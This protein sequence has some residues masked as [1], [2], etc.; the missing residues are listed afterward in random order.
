[1]RD[2]LREKFPRSWLFVIVLLSGGLLLSLYS[3]FEYVRLIHFPMSG[4]AICNFTETLNCE[5]AILSRYS[6]VFGISLGSFGAL[7]Y[8]LSLLFFLFFTPPEGETPDGALSG[9]FIF[10]TASLAISIALFAV[11]LLALD[12]L[13]PVCIALYLV[14]LCLW[15]TIWRMDGESRLLT[16]IKGGGSA[17]LSF[18]QYL[19]GLPRIILA[20]ESRLQDGAKVFGVLLCAMLLLCS[21]VLFKL[22]LGGIY[23]PS[24]D[25]QVLFNEWKS[26]SEEHIPFESENLYQ[27]DFRK[28]PRDAEIRIVEFFDYECPACRIF[29]FDLKDL[30]AE[31]G[32]H[33]SVEYRNYP[34]DSSCNSKL[35]TTGHQYACDAAEI[36]RCA[37]E[38]D[39]FFEA[40]EY[41]LTLEEFDSRDPQADK[42]GALRS[43]IAELE[44]DRELMIDCLSSNR[45]MIAIQRDIEIANRLNLPGTPAVWINGRRFESLR[46]L[47]DFVEHLIAQGRQ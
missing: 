42:G 18:T 47:R 2:Y 34:L 30:I 39:Q 44:L 4:D 45:Q 46:S 10:A 19:G 38:Q 40:H 43:I 5:S 15:I 11:S 28:G 27:R 3:S 17:V 16:R 21:D 14:S 36:A 9:F 6:S 1:M 23:R 33:I 35:T 12:S 29:Y 24:A 13:C 31:F 7:F 25:M 20:S 22:I 8:G 26:K 37:G 41:I 32:D